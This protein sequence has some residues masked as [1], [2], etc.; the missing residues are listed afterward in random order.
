MA[1]MKSIYQ[2][3][4]NDKKLFGNGISIPEDGAF[5][6]SVVDAAIALKSV[7]RRIK[8]SVDDR[9]IT[10]WC[11]KFKNTDGADVISFY[12]RNGVASFNETKIYGNIVEYN[13][14][15][16]G[17]CQRKYSV[18]WE[19]KE[20]NSDSVLWNCKDFEKLPYSSDNDA[21]IKKFDAIKEELIAR[22]ETSDN[23]VKKTATTHEEYTFTNGYGNVVSVI[24]EE[25]IYFTDGTKIKTQLLV[26]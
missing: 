12:D 20:G 26:F 23:K 8:K 21:A 13:L 5:F 15:P 24:K 3:R 18:D 6:E 17:Y 14:Y 2:I 4:F 25:E 7:Y 1:N 9:K 11:Q 19:I 10:G 16:A 22:Y